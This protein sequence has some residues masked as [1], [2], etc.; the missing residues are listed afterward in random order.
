MTEQEI[1]GEING[2]KQQLNQSDY[3]VMKAVERIFSA[4]SITDLLS[5]VSAAAKEIAEIIAQRQEWRAKI[6]ELEA[7]EPDQPEAPQA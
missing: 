5:A 2:Y 7:V 3:K 6:N 4:S 1:A